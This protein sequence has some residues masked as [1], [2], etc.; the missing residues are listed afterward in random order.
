[1]GWR[2]KALLLALSGLLA[3][4]AAAQEVP[5]PRGVNS[6]V[7]G[8]AEEFRLPGPARVCLMTTSIDIE[9][10]ENAF[11][12]YLGIHFGS[13]RI[14]RANGTSFLVREGSFSQPPGRP[15]F[16]Q[17]WRGRTIARVRGDGRPAYYM[18]A[19][20]EHA[21]DDEQPRVSVDGDALGRDRDRAILDRI[22]VHRDTPSG[23][24]RRFL[25]G[26]ETL[27]GDS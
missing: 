4:A 8:T 22:L 5:P 24:R 7:L 3:A 19:A 20:S 14:V 25:Y 13:V 27:L 1:M 2:I 18:Y 12:D 21:P 15:R 23:C 10:G 16:E 6:I 17:D 9:A 11:L 26:W